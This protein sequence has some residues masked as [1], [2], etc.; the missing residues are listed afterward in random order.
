M[1]GLT[2]RTHEQL[3]SSLTGRNQNQME[4]IAHRD[5]SN[6]LNEVPRQPRHDVHDWTAP[7]A[8]TVTTS[9]YTPIEQLE[10]LK[11]AKHIES[12]RTSTLKYYVYDD[13]RI[14][15]RQNP[16][17]NWNDEEPYVIDVFLNTNTSWRVTDPDLADLFIVPTPLLGYL[18]MFDHLR[19]SVKALTNHS[20]FQKTR[21]NRHVIFAVDGRYFDVGFMTRSRYTKW[22]NEQLAAKLVNATIVMNYDTLTCKKLHDD[23]RDHG[24]WNRYFA[25]VKPILNYTFSIGLVAGSSLPVIP[26]SYDRFQT[27]E[28]TLFY[29]TR[30]KGSKFNSTQYRWAPIN[31]TLPYKATIG[32]EIP[33]EQ[34]IQRFTSSKFCLVIRGDTPNS[35]ALLRAVKVGCIPVVVSDYYPVFS[36]TLKT[37][38][39][40]RDFSIFLDE[41]AFLENPQQQLE[42]LQEISEVDIRKKLVALQYAQ[43][44]TCPDHPDSLFIPALLREA[45]ASFLPTYEH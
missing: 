34:W 10:A 31:V 12:L 24:D 30:D 3:V 36:P 42:S 28:Y 43:Q 22:F 6:D 26:P 41:K 39:D 27:M 21:G 44:I 33:P 29:H 40:I 37:S 14:C 32:Y 23:N 13:P 20:V 1:H 7:M 16:R 15:R 5:D 45:D 8:T 18:N 2:G 38:L 17:I 25:S 4:R 9:A 35:H 19:S 11:Y